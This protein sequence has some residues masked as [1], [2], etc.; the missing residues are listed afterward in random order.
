MRTSTKKMVDGYDPIATT[1]RLLEDAGAMISEYR[2][3]KA[4][5]QEEL[6]SLMGLGKAQISKI[7]RRGNLTTSTVS[8]AFKALGANIKLQTEP[9]IDQ[10]IEPL[11]IRD[12]VLC[13]REFAQKHGLTRA[14]AFSYLNR[15]GGI[16]FY[17]EFHDV[18]LEESIDHTIDDLTQACRAKGGRL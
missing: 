17:L 12:L 2:K 4:L 13:I 15:F 5:T 3:S 9:I 10:D 16:D 6:G 18:E 14:Q 7:E 11:I 1:P 8:R